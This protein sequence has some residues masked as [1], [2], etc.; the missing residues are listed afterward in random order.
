VGH[1]KAAQIAVAG[2]IALLAAILSL[3]VMVAISD[4]GSRL[5]LTVPALVPV[6]LCLWL[7]PER[8]VG[9]RAV[10]CVMTLVV[11]IGAGVVALLLGG[12]LQDTVG[13]LFPASS[14]PYAL[15]WGPVIVVM[16]GSILARARSGSPLL[17][18]WA[19]WWIP[20]VTGTVWA[21]PLVSVLIRLPSADPLG[22]GLLMLAAPTWGMSAWVGAV[23]VLI[24]HARFTRG[25]LTM[26]STPTNRGSELV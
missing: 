14:S 9:A 6:A 5:L 18:L 24:A 13:T 26:A 10:L 8:G 23:S 2:P 15:L 22:A 11:S 21:E 17:G 20:V 12:P 25:H 19:L 1:S 7:N 3:A 4:L 16:V